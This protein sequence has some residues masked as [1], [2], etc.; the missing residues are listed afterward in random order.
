MLLVVHATNATT[1]VTVLTTYLGSSFFIPDTIAVRILCDCST[2]CSGSWQKNRKCP[3][4]IQK[5]STNRNIPQPLFAIA[6]KLQSKHFKILRNKNQTLCRVF[7]RFLSSQ[8]F[9][10]S[11]GLWDL[12]NIISSTYLDSWSNESSRRTSPAAGYYIQPWLYVNDIFIIENW[13]GRELHQPN[14]LIWMKIMFLLQDTG[15]GKNLLTLKRLYA[16]KWQYCVLLLN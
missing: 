1:S 7:F 13:A 15:Q 11:R 9:V 14:F 16:F 2:K 8:S 4:V 5:D 10:K 6:K 3:L 12:I